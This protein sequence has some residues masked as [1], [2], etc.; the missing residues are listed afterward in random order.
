MYRIRNQITRLLVLSGLSSFQ[1]AGASWVALLAARGFSLVEIGLA[2]S[3]FHAASLLFELPSGV[4]ADVFGRK[5]SL[6]MSQLMFVLSAL[7][8]AF[9]DR[10]PGVCLALAL[11]AWGYNF[12]SGAREALAYDGLKADGQEDRYLDFSARELSIYRIGNASAILCA[13]LALRLGFRAAYLLDAVL[14]L[15]ALAMACGL[16]EVKTE[17]RAFTSS[18]PARIAECF[19]KSLGFLVH[20]IPAVRVML[21]NALVG[22]F[23]ILT[24]FFLQAQLPAAGVEEAM[25]GPVLFIISLGGA[26]GA[27]LSSRLK[28]KYGWALALCG[29]GAVIGALCG[30]SK[31]PAVMCAGGFMANLLSD[32]LE[33]RTDALLNDRFPSGQRSTLLSA[34][35]LVFSL[36][37]IVL[38]PLAGMFFA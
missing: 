19:R 25:L 32:L 15:V 3:C 34:A 38:S 13:G 11:D 8:M 21:A 23:S 17:E 6:V 20:N 14:G 24:V 18:V 7:C 4:I 9:A 33:V 36:V 22:A 16:H 30:A 5:K 35:S 2:E 12:A 31:L 29:S 37:M 27:R 1:L 28:V 26:I 10:L